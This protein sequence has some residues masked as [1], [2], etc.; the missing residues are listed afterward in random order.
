R[1][2]GG[3][4]GTGGVAA[5]QSDLST[6]A[7]F[8]GAGGQG[9]W[10]CCWVGGGA[11]G[12]SGG[13]V[14]LLANHV[15]L[16]GSI[17]ANGTSG[18]PATFPAGGGGGGSGGSVFV[19]ARTASLSPNSISAVGGSG[20]AGAGNGGSGAAGRIR[21]EYCESISGD[22]TNAVQAS[23]NACSLVQRTD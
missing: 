22:A 21:V 14:V 9:A 23:S 12:Q 20:G 17:A 19:R 13:I 1:N 3:P 15:V 8:G 18:L 5:G 6:V 11:G 2:S 4:V 16:N 10:G 7:I